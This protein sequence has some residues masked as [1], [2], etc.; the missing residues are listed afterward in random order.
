MA[1]QTW[2]HL[3]R[4]DGGNCAKGAGEK[5]GT[6]REAGVGKGTRIKQGFCGGEEGGKTTGKGGS[7]GPTRQG[8]DGNVPAVGE[9]HEKTQGRQ[10]VEHLNGRGG[11]KRTL[12]PDRIQVDD[13]GMDTSGNDDNGGREKSGQKKAERVSG[14][15]SR[16]QGS[17]PSGNPSFGE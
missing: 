6:S 16:W 2:G 5:H 10:F 17:L 7:F 12:I 13:R 15:T 14:G 9:K 8:G 1:E 4:V 3:G 11:A